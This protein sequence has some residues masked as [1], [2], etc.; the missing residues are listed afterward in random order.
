MKKLAVLISG[1]GSNL[2]AIINACKNADFP[3]QI[4][5]VASNNP[6]AKGLEKAKAAGIPTVCV[7]SKDFDT[8]TAFEIELLKSLKEYEVDIV[9]LAGF[10]RILS[11][12]FVEAW[13]TILNIHPSL[14]PKYKGLNTHERAIENGDSEAGCSVHNV[15][16]ELD[17]GDIILQL[18]VPILKGDTPDI[19][20]EKVLA[21]EHIAYPKAI[22]ITAERLSQ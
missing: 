9:C 10:M 13:P 14:L 3:A 5:V 18:R 17:S 12:V 6:N 7:N 1:T 11:P 15:T 16:Q 8:R 21:Q 2:G 20:A 19:L 22:K 4:S